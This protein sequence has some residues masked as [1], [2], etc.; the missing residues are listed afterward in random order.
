MTDSSDRVELPVACSLG[1]DDG[2]ARLRRWQRLADTANP[3]ALRD[4]PQL[5]VRFE[6]SPGVREEF[7]TL[8]AAE[9]ECCSFVSWSVVQDGAAPVLLLTADRYAADM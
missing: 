2:P 6:P 9:A 5:K 7:E 4:G 3:V 8:A 1:P